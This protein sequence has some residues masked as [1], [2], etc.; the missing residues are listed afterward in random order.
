MLFT[1]TAPTTN[2]GVTRASKTQ[3]RWC[4]CPGEI[5][6]PTQDNDHL[7]KNYFCCIWQRC[8]SIYNGHW[9]SSPDP[10]GCNLGCLMRRSVDVR[11]Q[12]VP[13]PDLPIRR[14]TGFPSSKRQ[15][16]TRRGNKPLPKQGLVCIQ[17]PVMTRSPAVHQNCSN[18]KPGDDQSF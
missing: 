18:N 14:L 9:G 15:V 7:S 13:R 17:I 4:R 6:Q 2:Q 10:G 1:R 8:R 3:Q 12:S 16:N 5:P 11:V